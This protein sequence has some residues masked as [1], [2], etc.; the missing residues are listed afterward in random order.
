LRGVNVADF[1]PVL[2]DLCFLSLG[3]KL[4]EKG[5]GTVRRRGKE[6]K[7]EMKKDGTAGGKVNLFRFVG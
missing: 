2:I 4:V 5:L 1:I 7:K 3:N 6:A